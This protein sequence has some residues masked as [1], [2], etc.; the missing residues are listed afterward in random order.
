M[1]GN[2]EKLDK[3]RLS[4]LMSERGICSRRD[5]DRL[6][7]RGLVK[8]DGAIVSELG[9]K[10]DHNARIELLGE[11]K[12]ELKSQV[13]VLLNKPVGFVSAQPER[14]YRSALDLIRNENRSTDEA[15]RLKDEHFKGLGPAG[16]LDI[17][18][19]GLMIYTQDGALAKKIIGEN[20]ECEK[21]YLV[22]VEGRLSDQDLK[23]L[24]HG[25]SLDGVALKKAHVEWVNEDQL[26][27]VL[28]E[29]K[30]R[31]IRRMC[32]AVGLKVTGLKRVRVG[33]LRLGT[34]KEGQWRF[35]KP[36]EYDLLGDS[37]TSPGP[38]SKPQFRRR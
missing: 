8:V 16:R 18:S 25:L 32:E 6:I 5:A 23:R 21:E 12:Q 33:G 2:G 37:T 27:F 17:D 31:Q 15:Q 22:R 11:A 36:D 38:R 10:V 9:S 20:S 7:A 4:K 14:G 26:R 1:P 30:K 28:I 13:T 24:C 35:L 3:V 34:L 29:G 19:Q